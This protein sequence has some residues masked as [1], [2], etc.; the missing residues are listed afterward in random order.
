MALWSTQPPIQRVQGALSLGVIRP[1]RES[2]HSPP[3]SAEFKECV[4][5]YLHSPNTP[6]WR[7]AQLK[8]STGTTLLLPFTSTLPLSL[9]DFGNVTD[10]CR[11]SIQLIFLSLVFS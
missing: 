10:G 11:T 7:G 2:D 5:L 4:E 8:I 3:F 9:Y 1:G 6:A